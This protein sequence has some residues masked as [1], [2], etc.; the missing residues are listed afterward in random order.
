LA[1][2][3][4]ARDEGRLHLHPSFASKYLS[5]RRD[6]IVYVPPNYQNTNARHPVLYMQ[7][8]QNLFDP[9]TAFAGNDWGAD[10]TADEM[11]SRGEIEPCIIVGIYN[12][13]T[14]RISEYAPT[15][16]KRHRK[17]GKANRYAEMLA[18]EV[19]PF[20]DHEYRTLKAAKFSAVGGSS[21]G[22][23]VTLVA[24]LQ[25]PRVFGQLAV[26]SPS[27]WW[28]QRSVLR[29]VEE[30]QEAVRPRMWVDVGTAEGSGP[31]HVVEDARAL[32]E[33][34]LRKGWNEG[35]DLA[36]HEVQGAEHSERAWGA[37]FGA[38][39]G[40]LFGRR[41]DGLRNKVG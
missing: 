8:G 18:R 37:R 39:L 9:A 26:I 28:D 19:K 20:I 35:R 12:T 3:R 7:D 16:D 33:A 41:G 29:W 40:F 36:Y 27:V 13:G 22:G 24:G 11:I 4:R 2:Q 14:K 31:H 6:L 10:I 38:V 21:L 25:Y 34:L 5:T 1:E 32:R 23:L 15:R 30:Y 17:G